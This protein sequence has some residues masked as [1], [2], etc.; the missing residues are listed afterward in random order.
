[1]IC[2][3]FTNNCKSRVLSHISGLAN[4][5]GVLS[6]LHRITAYDVLH[7]IYY[8]WKVF[9]FVILLTFFMQ[10]FITDMISVGPLVIAA[11]SLT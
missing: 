11:L 2:C 8:K 6:L 4:I 5:H 7:I 3:L 9:G 1:M 10:V